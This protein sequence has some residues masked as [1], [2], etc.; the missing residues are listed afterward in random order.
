MN[1]RTKVVFTFFLL[2]ISVAGVFAQGVITGLVLD[3]AT[4]E[5]LPGV[6]VQIEQTVLGA[7]TNLKGAFIIKRVPYGTFSL[8]IS[9]IG[10]R[11]ARVAV[12]VTSDER[13]VVKVRLKE[14]PVEIDP[15]VVTASKWQQEAASTPSTIEVLTANDIRQKSQI[16]IEDVLKTAAGVQILQENV[17]IRGSD[18]WTFGIGSRVL[19]MMD[20][21]PIT[22][23]D[24]GRVNWFIVPPSDIE[25]IEVVRGS[26]SA[27]YGSS[28]MGGV[29]NFITSDPGP[30]TETYLRTTFGVY[31]NFKQFPEFQDGM[32][33]FNRVDFRHSRQ[34]GNLGMRLSG[35]RSS[36]VGYVE[37]S[38]Y[39]LYN[40]SGKFVYNFDDGSKWSLFGN[41][42]FNDREAFVLWKNQT[43]ATLVAIGERGKRQEQWGVTL[44][45]KYSRPI[46]SKA[47]VELHASF[48]SSLLG[49][50]ATD[51]DFTPAIGIWGTLQAT[52]LPWNKLLLIGGSDFKYDR[53]KADVY[54]ERKAFLIAP[55]VQADLRLFTKLNLTLGARYDRYKIAETDTSFILPEARLFDRFTPKIGLNYHPFEGTTIRA[56]FSN[57]FKFPNIFHLYFGNQE[58][59]NF[60]WV[61]NPSLK[62]ETSWSYELGIKQEIT[63][64]SY[65]ELTGFY[66]KVNDL[67]EP[68]ADGA[69]ASF[70]NTT[71]VEIPGIEFAARGS[72]WDN[73][74][75]LRVNFTYLNPHNT[76]T[77]ELLTH[78]QKLIAYIEPSI[79]FGNFEL[80]A[81]YIFS[82]AQEQYLLPPEDEHQFVP[83]KVFTARVLYYWKKAS[84]M[85]G[86]E[87][88]FNYAYTLRDKFLEEPRKFFSTLTLNF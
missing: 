47:A 29:I 28:A 4:N 11:T 12:N 86:T 23:S 43:E 67:I 18:G 14:A 25:R 34:I 79:R 71:E 1:T 44:S 70:R 41:Y 88:M 45:T 35:S 51:V 60:T 32:L 81:D 5:G 56:N 84:L 3:D 85:I 59:A 26:G 49:T 39:D 78:R 42:M 74:L 58:I 63:Q 2:L 21:V 80:Q 6:N 48:I 24:L 55:Y 62:S 37:N 27:I 66:T 33:N 50:Q 8:R 64:N 82:S 31:D 10:F 54:G 73:R 75:R 36:S 38:A 52:Y 30:A 13:A 53:V 22:T 57:G 68:G 15:V 72:W 69:T 17:N 46:S 65:V 61:A 83:Q 19:V 7:S 40:F 76:E 9:M 87:N 77:K 20:G 16:R